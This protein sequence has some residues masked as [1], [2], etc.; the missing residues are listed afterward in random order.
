MNCHKT[1]E[2]ETILD[3]SSAWIAIPT[4]THVTSICQELQSKKFTNQ[5]LTQLK[6]WRKMFEGKFSLF[7][8]K[9]FNV[10]FLWRCQEY[11]QNIGGHFQ[12]LLLYGCISFLMCLVCRFTTCACS[13]LPRGH[14]MTRGMSWLFCLRGSLFSY[15]AC[16]KLTVEIGL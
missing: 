2:S 4:S 11:V 8:K 10:N 5:T 9:Y 6:H 12:H 16:R 3:I 15:H 13:P 14:D 1:P 7:P